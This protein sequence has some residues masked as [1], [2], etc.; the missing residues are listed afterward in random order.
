MDLSYSKQTPECLFK[1]NFKL[2]IPWYI[3]SKHT[4]LC[5]WRCCL[6]TSCSSQTPDCDSYQS[7][8][9]CTEKRKGKQKMRPKNKKRYSLKNISIRTQ[10]SAELWPDPST[11]LWWTAGVP[12]AVWACRWYW[13]SCG[14]DSRAPSCPCYWSCHSSQCLDR[15]ESGSTCSS[16]SSATSPCWNM[17]RSD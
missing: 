3:T 5:H 13:A 12:A 14:W 7:L 4:N 1:C 10:R 17:D 8:T 15:P 11:C 9:C 16:C 2:M 6:I